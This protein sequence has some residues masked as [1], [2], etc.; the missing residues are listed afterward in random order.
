MD[1]LAA[2]EDENPAKGTRR[3]RIAAF[4]DTI[5]ADTPG[6]DELIRLVD[7]P[8]IPH[9]DGTTRSGQSVAI[10]LSRL[11][12]DTTANPVLDHRAKRCRCYR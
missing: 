5:P 1:I 11:G 10:T 3:C 12:C 6:R 2:L 4:L 8:H 7:T 9:A